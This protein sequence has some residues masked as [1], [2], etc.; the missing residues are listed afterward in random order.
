MSDLDKLMQKMKSG[1]VI[2]AKKEEIPVPTPTPSEIEEEEASDEDF[3]EDGDEDEEGE[4]KP[5]VKPKKPEKQADPVEEEI[6]LTPDQ[7]V[8]LFHDDGIY[9]REMMI[10]QKE[11]NALLRAIAQILMENAKRK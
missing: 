11:R 10:V 1:R 3:D 9:R 5:L 6:E 4:E 2:P 8:A 7:E